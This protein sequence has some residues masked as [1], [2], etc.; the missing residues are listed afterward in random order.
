VIVV[1]AVVLRS[2]PARPVRVEMAG[3]VSAENHDSPA[4][5]NHTVP[6]KLKFCGFRMDV[7]IFRGRSINLLWENATR[8]YAVLFHLSKVFF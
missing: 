7:G 4:V 8:P 6:N 5:K 1:G 3:G 2:F